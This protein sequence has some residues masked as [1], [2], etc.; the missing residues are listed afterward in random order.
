MEQGRNGEA[1]IL[2]GPSL[3]Y[4]QMMEQWQTIC[5]VPAPKIWLPGGMAKAS[6]KA[7]SVL[8]RAFKLKLALSSEA[9]E[10]QANYTFYASAAKAQRELGWQPRPLEQTFKEVLDYKMARRKK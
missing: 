4:K 1:Y 6:S 7:V 10:T 8:E 3:T 2:S 5:G 9:L